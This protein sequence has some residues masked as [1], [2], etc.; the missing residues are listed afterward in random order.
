MQASAGRG[1]G[2]MFLP[3]VGQ[4]VVVSYLE[5]DPDNPLVTGIVYNAD[6]MPAYQLPD[7]KT[8]S[9]FKTNSSSGGEGHNELRFED[10]ADEEQIYLHAERNLEM[11]VKNDSLARTFGHRH[12]IIGAEKDGSKTGDQREMV[13]GDQHLNIK[14][15]QTHHV[16]GSTQLMIGNG[17]ASDG[18]KLD[19]VVEKKETRKIG[20]EGFH[21]TV[22]GDRNEKVQGSA[23]DHVAMSRAEKVG[24][25]YALDAGMEVHL[26]AGMNVV[27][28]AG[29]QL[30]LKAG[31][32]FVTIGPAGVSIMGTLVNINS[33]GAPGSGSGANPTDPDQPQEAAPTEPDVADDSKTGRKSCD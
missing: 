13:Y 29:M 1:W 8:K 25:N 7:E 14:G 18:G 12:Q 20:M 16:E 19:V 17:G 30:T 22:E 27:I 6:Q 32:N 21:L 9:Y 4:E 31:T 33:G 11:R 24:M 2:S 3:R 5:G 26:K 15:S 28:E 23:S 10:K